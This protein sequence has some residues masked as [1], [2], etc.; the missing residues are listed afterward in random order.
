MSIEAGS[1]PVVSRHMST[2]H[3]F[4]ST[5]RRLSPQQ[6]ETV[7]SLT[8]AAIIVLRNTGYSK[9][10]VRLVAAEA[11]VAPATAYTYFSSKNHLVSELFWR[12]LVELPEDPG[13]GRTQAER[14]SA[15]MRDVALL[16]SDEPEMAAAVT[17]ALLGDDPEVRHLR[18]RI[19]L[20][21]RRRL[22]SALDP[23]GRTDTSTGGAETTTGEP[24]AHADPDVLEALEVIWSGGLVRAGM[25][26]QT[27]AEIADRLE[28][29]ARLILE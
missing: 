21:I 3:D 25:G 4:E 28:T 10:T 26:H 29:F 27:Y 16:V 8:E 22:A 13:A 12:R 2:T 1:S 5:R 11:G 14:V 23:G 19:G 7:A 18:I 20:D 9:L 17:A 24:G 6:A 15:V